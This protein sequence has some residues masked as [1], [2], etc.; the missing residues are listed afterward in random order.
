MSQSL[1]PLAGSIAYVDETDVLRTTVCVDMS[2]QIDKLM[3]LSSQL[4]L[5]T[6]SIHVPSSSLPLL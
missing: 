3:S 2:L 4:R 6:V 1:A 5:V